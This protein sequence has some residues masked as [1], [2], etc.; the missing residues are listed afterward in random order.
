VYEASKQ[1]PRY[2]VEAICGAWRETDD[3]KDLL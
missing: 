3:D 2:H 1:R